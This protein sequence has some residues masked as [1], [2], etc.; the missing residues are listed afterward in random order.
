MDSATLLIQVGRVVNS[1]PQLWRE[2]VIISWKLLICPSIW[3]WALI[4]IRACIVNHN[5][6]RT[7]INVEPDTNSSAR[8]VKMKVAIASISVYL[9]FTVSFKKVKTRCF[10]VWL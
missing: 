6:N 9:L 1:S 7:S 10:P 2:R 8:E 5:K 4:E 3:Y